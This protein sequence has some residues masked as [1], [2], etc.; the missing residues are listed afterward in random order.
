MDTERPRAGGR[1]LWGPQAAWL[2]LTEGEVRSAVVEE[3]RHEIGIKEN[4]KHVQASE[5]I[6]VSGDQYKDRRVALKARFRM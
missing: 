4:G 1:A 3:L 6:V 2:C 5:G